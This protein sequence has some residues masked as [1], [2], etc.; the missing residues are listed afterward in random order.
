MP[1]KAEFKNL[2]Q[3]FQLSG[4]VSS[5]ILLFESKNMDI[6]T[7][8]YTRASFI[9]RRAVFERNKEEV[10]LVKPKTLVTRSTLFE[11]SQEKGKSNI[12]TEFNMKVCLTITKIFY[13]FFC[14]FFFTC[15]DSY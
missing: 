14:F 9:K 8:I 1:S 15:F 6:K 2:S 3:T 4:L 12:R 10:P 5:K 11:K 7:K 13:I